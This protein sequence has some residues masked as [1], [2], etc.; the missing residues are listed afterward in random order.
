LAIA[1]SQS[2]LHSTSWLG[3][4]WSSDD[5]YFRVAG[6]VPD[7][8]RPYVRRNFS[9]TPPNTTTTQGH[10]DD[11]FGSL[12]IL[13]LEL[14]FGTPLSKSPFRERYQ[15]P[16]GT[17]DFVMDLAAAQAWAD[18]HME[19]VEGNTGQGYG[20]AVL[21][22]LNKR[23]LTPREKMWRQDLHRAVILPIQKAYQAMTT[24]TTNL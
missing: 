11:S 14:C 19:G 12:G 16:D 20:D 15:S 3:H 2:Q 21:W 10:R 5:I 7:V 17:P 24:T 22:C 13:L 23:T 9:S 18:S 4:R 6:G 1:S 8:G